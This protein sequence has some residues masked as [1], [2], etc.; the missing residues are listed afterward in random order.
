MSN[1][2]GITINVNNVRVIGEITHRSEADIVVKIISPYQQLSNGLHIP[3]FSRP[4]HSFLAEYGDRTAENLLK[5]LFELGL[6]LGEEI[7]FISNQMCLHFH[8]GDYSNSASQDRFFGSTF[9][10]AVPVGTREEVL[11]QLK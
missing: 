6:Y 1:R 8:D 11:R 5:Y 3:Y 9:P 4:Y 7:G 2:Q 10:F